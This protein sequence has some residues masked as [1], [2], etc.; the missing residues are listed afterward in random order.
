MVQVEF[1]VLTRRVQGG[2]SIS[3]VHVSGVKE[4]VQ[5]G[6]FLHQQRRGREIM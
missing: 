4:A 1:L 3:R 2:P 6:C 5:R